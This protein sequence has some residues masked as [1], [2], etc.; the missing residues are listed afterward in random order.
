MTWRELDE[1]SGKLAAYI[2]RTCQTK[3]PVIV[4]GHKDPWMLVCFLACVKSG[5]AYCPI[6]ISVPL[7]RVQDIIGEVSP[8]L[9]LAVESLEMGD[10]PILTRADILTS[11]EKE[12]KTL[13]Q[14]YAVSAEDIFYI[15][16]TSGS[17]GTPKGVQITRDCLDNFIRWGLTLGPG[18]NEGKRQVFLNQAPFS[19]DLSVMDV[20]L[21]LYSGGCLYALSKEVQGD[22]SALLDALED[23]HAEVWVSTPSFADVCLSDKKF[24]EA[25][26]PDIKA[27][28]FC[29]E[30]LS[31]RTADRL[32]NAFPRA[33]I[34]NT[35]GP[36]E[37]TVAVTQVKITADLRLHPPLPVG[38]E[39]PGTWI[40]I[41]DAEGK[42][43]P[44]G[45]PGEIVI[46]GDSVSI[47]YWK[48][49]KLTAQVFGTRKIN[50]RSYRT[51]RTGDI[52]IK[53][54]GQLYYQG[55]MDF[56]VKLHGYRIELGDIEGNLLKVAGVSAAAVLPVS[57]NDKVTHLIAYVVLERRE[58]DFA[59]GQ[60]LR[61]DLRALVPEYMIPKKFVFLDRLPMTNNGKVDRR[62][63]G[64]DRK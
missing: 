33:A 49:P 39:K 59:D 8:E 5:R 15:I 32:A 45:E 51:Y 47:G 21:S 38:E 44:D 40:F 2:Q 41:Q 54:A 60:R 4:Y 16:F 25:L 29:G 11:T 24:C 63:L 6:D 35:Y 18:L 64:G 19:F 48:N 3:T 61:R 46:A 36:T 58:D 50:N 27:F 57:R 20:Y 12:P 26:L 13:E 14:E 31:G 28:L 9:I 7:N 1:R 34:V 30:T 53:R 22:M 52:G 62:A 10:A 43:L 42:D 56:Q 55:R 37:S 17:T 23:S